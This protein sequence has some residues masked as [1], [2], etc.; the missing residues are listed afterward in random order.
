MSVI[1]AKKFDGRDL[2]KKVAKCP[3]IRESRHGKGDHEVHVAINGNIATI[4]NRT[5][6]KGIYHTIC[7]QLKQLGIVVAVLALFIL[8]IA[9]NI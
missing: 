1:H 8:I 4:P 7:K 6:G 9:V 2:N 3:E 5:L